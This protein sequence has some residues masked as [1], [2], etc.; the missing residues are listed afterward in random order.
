MRLEGVYKAKQVL[1]KEEFASPKTPKMPEP[2]R[3]TSK[4]EIIMN[5]PFRPK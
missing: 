5:K 4:G 1:K 3:I 2:T